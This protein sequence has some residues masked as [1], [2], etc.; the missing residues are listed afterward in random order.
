L[1]LKFAE[2]IGFTYE[3]A[4]VPD[5][6]WGTLLG[7]GKWNGL[8]LEL[9]NRKVDVA[10]SSLMI[11]SEREAVVDF[12]V[13]FMDSGVAILTAKRTGII[14]PTAFLGES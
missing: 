5:G 11:N 3:L 7:H 9:I 10:F 12:S 1:L 4:R 8:I 14:S 2:D 6:R 13:P